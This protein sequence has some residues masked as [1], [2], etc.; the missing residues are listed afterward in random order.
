MPNVA[1]VNTALLTK[2]LLETE[3]AW[4]PNQADIENKD[5][6]AKT[7][8]ALITNQ[9]PKEA[10]FIAKITDPEKDY[11]VKVYWP[12]FCGK[13]AQD[14]AT[15]VCGD[16]GGTMADVKEK[17]YKIESCIEDGFAIEENKLKDSLI[18]KDQFIIQQSNAAI[19]RLIEKLNT[20]AIAFAHANIGYNAGGQFDFTLGTFVSEVPNNEYNT[21]L[22]P[23]LMYD[24]MMNRMSNA[25]VIDGGK[26]FLPFMNAKLD[27]ANADGKGDAARAS[28]FNATFDPFG[29]AA[30]GLSDRTFAITPYSYA[31]LTKNYVQSR[32]P[33]LDEALGSRGLYKYSFPLPG[34]GIMVDAFMQRVCV[35]GAKQRYTIKWLYKIHYDFVL[36]PTGCDQGGGNIVT[37]IVEYKKLV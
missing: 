11:D 29:F 32:V 37:G 27:G 12:D 6:Q 30:A 9:L 8:D 10:G 18:V 33:V 4:G 20:K 35:D 19:K 31:F 24:M 34:Y 23:K 21:E 25:F 17:A 15:D 5:V 13:T 1:G 3:R 7:F 28:L 14:C 26:L 22:M 36:N 2:V 16:L